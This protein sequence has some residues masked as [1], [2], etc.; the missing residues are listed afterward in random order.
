MLQDQEPT[1]AGCTRVLPYLLWWLRVIV[2]FL[3]QIWHKTV[4]VR[5]LAIE[6]SCD[7]T[8]AAVVRDRHIE[9]N[10]VASQIA[11]HQAFG[12]VVPE[13]ASRAHL[14]TINDVIATAIA[15]ANCDWG[16]IDAIAVTCAPGLVGSLL[17]GLTAAKTLAIV[18]RKPLVGVHHLEGHLYASYLAEPTLKPPFLCL[19]VSGGH[20]SLI[21][22]YGCGQYQLF[23]QTRDDAAGEA[24]DKVAR[25]LGLGYP[26]GPVLD[27]LAQSGN[28][29]AFTLPEGSISLPNGKVH[30]YDSSFS[31]LKT[32]VARL[33]SQLTATHGNHLP[34]AD[35]AASFQ[36]AVAQALTKR[37]IAAAV[38]HGFTTLAIGG[39]VAANS[40]LRHHLTTAATPLGIRLIFPPLSLCADNAAMIGCAA[41]DHFCQG[42]QSPLS[43]GAK[44]RLSLLELGELYGGGASQG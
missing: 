4:M 25:L 10:V 21:G 34:V 5:I 11:A 9:S 30:P 15:Q 28:P 2:C 36:K 24:Y 38:D 22:V 18:H 27:R 41:A 16:E 43:L 1:K 20:T 8:S 39:G 44:S 17:I 29:D 26:G 13:V 3:V 19:L 32:A 12:G 6:T 35:I 31:G 33:V 14:Q 42:E 37:A 7:E 40:G 23:G